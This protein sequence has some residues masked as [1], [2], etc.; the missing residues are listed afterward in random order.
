MELLGEIGGVLYVNDSK[1][2]NAA[3]A[4]PALAAYPPLGNGPRIHWILGGVAKGEGIGECESGLTH[5]ARAYL[6]GD[7]APMLARSLAGRV[8][9]EYCGTL[10]A[11]VHSATAQARAGDVILLSPIAAS[12]DQFRDFEARGD[13]FRGLVAALAADRGTEM[14]NGGNAA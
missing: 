14:H 10:D 2:T 12:F 8:A 11:A 4:A 6:I 7:A 5:V 13:A 1:A 9:N 3:S